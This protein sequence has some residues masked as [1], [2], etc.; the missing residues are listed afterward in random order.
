MQAV[1]GHQVDVAI[2]GCGPVGAF[3]ATLLGRRGHRVVVLE[4]HERAYDLPRA[5]HFDH[6]VG[7]L[8]QGIG[9]GDALRTISEPGSEYEWRNGAGQ[10]LLRF[11]GREVGPSGW[12]DSNMFWQP[13]L[14]RLL[15]GTAAGEPTVEV[16]RGCSLIGLVERDQNVQLTIQPTDGGPTEQVDAR[17]VLGCDGANS[18]VRDLLGVGVTDLGFFYDWLI[19]DLVLHQPRRFDPINLQVCDPARPTTVVSGGPGRRRWEFMRLPHE[20]VAELDD[21]GRAWE[22]LAPWNVRPADATLERHAVYRFQARWAE[23]WRE[24]RVLLAGDAA[25][26]MPPFAGQGMCAGIRDAANL[27]WKLDL[28]LAGRGADHLLDA[29]EI[30]RS[31]HVRAVIDLSM[32]L[33]RV[34]CVAD[35]AEAAERDANMAVGAELAGTQAQPPLPGLPAGVMRVGDGAAG[36]LFVQGR[37]LHHG[38]P[39]LFD[40]VAG[41]GWRLVV[42]GT[43]WFD[44]GSDDLAW[45]ESL[46]GAVVAIDPADDCDGTYAGWF[47]AQGAVAALQRPDLHVF[48]SAS[49]FTGVAELLSALRIALADPTARITDS[50][51]ADPAGRLLTEGNIQ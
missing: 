40:D 21:E 16:R 10:V 8:L 23:R 51:G 47:A 30:E 12:P 31:A 11:G 15:A 41:A 39:T 32:A 3:L 36:E 2:V 43:E 9:V 27:A 18:T 38:I 20:T 34:I 24:G 35:P 17:W 48:G 19:V 28:V 14:E 46:G 26:Q 29:Y 33:G 1:P 22:L 6:E 44:L 13:A 5:V 50:P 45:F 4:R 7:R 25:H 42:F 49:N 37:V